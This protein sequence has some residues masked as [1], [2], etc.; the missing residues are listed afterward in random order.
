V[1]AGVAAASVLIGLLGF[2]V[3]RSDVNINPT[4]RLDLNDPFSTLFVI[5]NEGAFSIHNVQFSCH[6]N[7]VEVRNYHLLVTDQPAPVDPPGEPSIEAHNSQDVTCFFG[8]MGMKIG[9]PR[10]SPRPIYNVADITLSV[11]YRPSFWWRRTKSQRFIA[12][13]DG[14]G[15]IVQWSHQS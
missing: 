10:N 1:W 11:S 14:H 3:L 12:R 15:H 4:V 5:T 8:A 7:D 2:V 9:T 13:T 6:M